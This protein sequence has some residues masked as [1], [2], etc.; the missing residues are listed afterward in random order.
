M[1]RKEQP[2]T[3]YKGFKIFAERTSNLTMHKV[4]QPTADSFMFF[5]IEKD[6]VTSAPISTTPVRTVVSAVC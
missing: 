3:E 1:G 6:T 4:R 2:T 5:N